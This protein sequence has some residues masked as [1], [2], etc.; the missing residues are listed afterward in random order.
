MAGVLGMGLANAE[1]KIDDKLSLSGFLDMSLTGSSPDAGPK[2]LNAG[3]DQFELDFMYKFAENLSARA[4]LNV[5]TWKSGNATLEQAYLTYTMGAASLMAGK[6]LSSSGF[7]AAEPTGLYQ[8]SVSKTMVYGGYQNGV[9]A[10]YTISPMISL[11]GAYVGSVWN[12]E[13]D[14]TKPGIEAQLSLTPIEGV[15]LKAAYLM[16]SEYQGVDDT[17]TAYLADRSLVN[18]W[19]MYAAGPL[20]VAAEVNMLMKWDEAEQSGLGYLAMANYKLSDALGITVRYSALKMEN[21]K[22]D[23]EI[24][25]SPGY[26]ISDSWF[27]LAEV[28]QELEAKLMSFVVE[29]I[30]SF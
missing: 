30:L 28:K 10:A 20:T 1:I 8:Y 21:G 26:A 27:V 25:L 2:T 4:D 29:S 16:E 12:D 3:F 23:N 19:G 5:E 22:N 9:A 6:F 17:G 13:S 24:T 15:T 18:V 7:E 14:L 11:Y